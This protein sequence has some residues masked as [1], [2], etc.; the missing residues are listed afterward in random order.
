MVH[1]II[2]GMSELPELDP[3]E[4]RVLGV[5]VEKELTTPDQFPLSLNALSSGCN[6][7]SNRDPAMSLSEAEVRVTIDALRAKGL[8]GSSHP[9]GG[10]V[11]RYHHSVREMWGVHAV[12]LAVLTELLLRGGQSIGELKTRCARMVPIESK[13]AVAHSLEK[14]AGRGFV[15]E[16]P[17]APGSRAPRWIQLLCSATGAGPESVPRPA[18]APASILPAEP[19]VPTLDKRVAK[20]ESEVAWLR[21][22]LQGLAVKLGETLED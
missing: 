18:P 1:A 8:M 15:R 7:K 22:Q 9:S 11:E 3:L 14:L 12:S 20:L 5:L 2:A 4:A 10:R 16:T 19:G 17:P 6:Q 13:E 21:H